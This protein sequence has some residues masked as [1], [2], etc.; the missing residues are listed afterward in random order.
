MRERPRRRVL[1]TLGGLVVG[2]AAGCTTTGETDAPTESVTTM[3]TSTPAET[4][5]TERTDVPTP[6][7]VATEAWT[8]DFSGGDVSGLQLPNR[9]RKPDTTGGPLYAATDAG[10]VANLG[11]ATGEVRWRFSAAGETASYG[12]PT[13]RQFGRTVVVVSETRNQE[14]LRNYVELVDSGSGDRRWVFEEREFL[15]PLGVVDDALYLAGEYI[16]A[17]P[18]ELGPNQDPT[19]EG[20]LHAVDLASGEERWRTTVPSL[21]NA[22]VADHGIYANTTTDDSSEHRLVAF[23]RDGTERWRKRAG[24]HLLPEPVAVED[25]VLAS[26]HGDSAALF[27][28]DGTERWRLS[29]WE[30]GPSQLAATSERL[31]VG[32]DPL[33]AIS[34]AGTERWRVDSHGGV[35]RPIRD[36]R[37]RPTLYVAGGRQVGAIDPESGTKRWSFDPENAKYV[38]VQAVVDG[39]LV[40]DTGISPHRT[41]FLLDEV[42]GELRGD[43][44]TERPYRTATAI[45][46]RLFAGAADAVYA[47]DVEG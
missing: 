18:S 14:T 42:T 1:Q 45:A 29:A 35:V 11:V 19:G 2:S 12:G 41:F 36:G 47:F 20:W 17:A 7:P 30:R 8:V 22:T 39:G 27:A 25:G 43:F 33:V 26:A 9:P 21:I 34:R 3:D 15:T 24:K 44:S 4:P 32:S 40:V 46:S 37:H 23:D 28:P 5:T 38:H 13:V 31:Y 16:R 6:D 10:T